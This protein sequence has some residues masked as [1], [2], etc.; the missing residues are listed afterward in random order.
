MSSTRELKS[1]FVDVHRSRVIRS[2]DIDTV[3]VN[4]HCRSNTLFAVSND[5]VHTCRSIDQ[6]R[7]AFE[8]YLEECFGSHP[9]VSELCVPLT[10]R[11]AAHDIR[12]WAGFALD[13]VSMIDSEGTVWV[14]VVRGNGVRVD[15]P[16][17]VVS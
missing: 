3:D 13:T 11:D 7:I 4:S 17:F 6:R 8:R 16:I 2:L 9:Y 1:G 14:E 12:K 10:L 5:C 15:V